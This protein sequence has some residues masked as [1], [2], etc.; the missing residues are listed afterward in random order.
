MEEL[1]QDAVTNNF[2]PIESARRTLRK[3]AV[4]GRPMDYAEINKRTTRLEKA[5]RKRANKYWNWALDPWA[6]RDVAEKLDKRIEELEHQVQELL[7][8]CYE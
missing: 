8:A 6:V 1:W 3:C 7:Q 5:F 2:D 4:K